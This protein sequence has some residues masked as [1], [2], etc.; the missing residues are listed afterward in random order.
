MQNVVEQNR[1]YAA[2][3]KRIRTP[4]NVRVRTWTGN[5]DSHRNYHG[6]V[7]LNESPL[8]LH[9]SWKRCSAE[10][11]KFVGCFELDLDKLLQHGLI[12]RDSGAGRARLRFYHGERDV[13]YIQAFKSSARLAVGEFFE[14]TEA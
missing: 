4:L 11:P 10:R 5:D 1:G 13:I 12:R 2:I 14:G 3:A 8:L 9:L 6:V 7:H